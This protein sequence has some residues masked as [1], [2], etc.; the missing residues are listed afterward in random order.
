M[1]YFLHQCAGEL[2]NHGKC[3]ITYLI[4]G[5]DHLWIKSWKFCNSF[6]VHA[7]I[8]KAFFAYKNPIDRRID[9]TKA[10]FF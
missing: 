1:H 8:D 10:Y 7:E 4:T 3:H 5:S 9:V 2:P 6:G